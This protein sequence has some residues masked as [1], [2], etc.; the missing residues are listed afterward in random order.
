MPVAFGPSDSEV[1][2]LFLV[3]PVFLPGVLFGLAQRVEQQQYGQSLLK[4]NCLTED[5]YVNPLLLGTGERPCMTMHTASATH[6]SL[7]VHTLLARRSKA[8]RAR[9]AVQRGFVQD[10][11][12]LCPTWES[13][14]IIPLKGTVNAAD[15]ATGGSETLRVARTHTHTHFCWRIWMLVWN[16]VDSKKGEAVLHTYTHTHRTSHHIT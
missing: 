15:P 3:I 12:I 5:K 4:E 2:F 9:C 10:H 7:S 11:W 16:S 1:S 14:H 6:R 8:I 13:E